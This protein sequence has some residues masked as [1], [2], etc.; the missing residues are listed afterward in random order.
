MSRHIVSYQCIMSFRISID[1]VWVKD[2]GWGERG[3]RTVLYSTWPQPENG[4]AGGLV[5]KIKRAPSQVR[6]YSIKRI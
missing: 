3:Q 1:I 5:K 2:K 6:L 4:L